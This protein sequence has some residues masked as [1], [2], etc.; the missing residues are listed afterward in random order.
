VRGQY[1]TSKTCSVDELVV[2][3]LVSIESGM[4]VPAD[5][6]LVEGMDIVCDETMYPEGLNNVKKLISYGVERNEENPDPFL[7]SRSFVKTGS[8]RALVLAVG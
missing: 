5:C 4:R 2:G 3:D 7:L 8:G 6:I 1:G